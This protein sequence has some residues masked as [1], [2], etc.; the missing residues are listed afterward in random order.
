MGVFTLGLGILARATETRNGFGSRAM[1][2]SCSFLSV[3]I[4]VYW[5]VPGAG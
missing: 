3:A 1:M 5:L 4:G 2:M